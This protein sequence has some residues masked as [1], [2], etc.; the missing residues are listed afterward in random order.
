M[1]IYKKVDYYELCRLCMCV[2]GKKFDLFKSTETTE[3]EIPSKL[4]KCIPVQ[5]SD[6][7]TE[8]SVHFFPCFFFAKNKKHPPPV[9]HLILRF[10]ECISR[11]GLVKNI[12]NF[13]YI[14]ILK[15]IYCVPPSLG[16]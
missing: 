16:F 13:F 3:R 8:M 6:G 1:S 4:R 11:S 5:V 14:S 15:Q 9:M 2:G 10:R 7:V 12:F